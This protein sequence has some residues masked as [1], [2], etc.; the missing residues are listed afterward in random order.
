[1]LLFR[2]AFAFPSESR[3]LVDFLYDSDL[4]WRNSEKIFELF[5]HIGFSVFLCGLGSIMKFSWVDAI[6]NDEQTYNNPKL[7]NKK[8]H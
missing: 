7:R 6:L 5:F 2:E 4:T 8:I 3:I 1:M